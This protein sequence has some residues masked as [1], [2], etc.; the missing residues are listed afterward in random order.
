MFPTRKVWNNAPE[1]FVDFYLRGNDVREYFKGAR[2]APR[3]FSEGWARR[4]FNYGNGGFVTAGF[5]SD[6]ARKFCHFVQ[7]ILSVSNTPVNM[8]LWMGTR[9]NSGRIL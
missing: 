9:Y 5:N 7:V 2:L 3:S 8:E 1:F 6:K 4:T